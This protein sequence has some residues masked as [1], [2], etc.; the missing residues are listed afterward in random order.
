MRHSAASLM[1][2]AGVPLEP[3]ADVLGRN[4]TRMAA[5]VDRHGLAAT[6]EAGAAPMQAHSGSLGRRLLPF[7]RPWRR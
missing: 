4:G 5:T 1:S 2:A 7:W 6:V 3:A